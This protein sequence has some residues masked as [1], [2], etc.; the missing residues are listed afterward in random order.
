[1]TAVL[2]L[3][4]LKTED[5]QIFD[6][7]FVQHYEVLCNYAFII[8]GD[9]DE[10]EDLVQEVFAKIWI[11][12]DRIPLKETNIGYFYR[13]I[14]NGCLDL[15]KHHK[16]KAKFESEITKS[17]TSLGE[18]L[19]DFELPLKVE[20]AINK[21]PEQCQKIF[22]LSRYEGLKYKEIAQQLNI[23]ENTVNTQIHRAL[24]ILKTELKDY[25]IV[26]IGILLK[27]M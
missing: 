18:L 15:K 12:K 25:L 26:L 22:R 7:F 4:H 14:K 20:E 6:Q 10:A 19:A 16:V 1:M 2:T 27:S 3:P 11:N 24:R 9:Y 21:L 23:S 5:A 8:L 13:S 17:S